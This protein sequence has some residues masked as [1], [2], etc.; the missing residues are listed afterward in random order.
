MQIVDNTYQV[1]DG[2]FISN[3]IGADAFGAENLIFPPIMIIMSI[4]LMFGSGSSAF[5]AKE[6]GE[7]H[8]EKANQLF[9]FLI[10]VLGAIGIVLSAVMFFLMPSIARLTGVSED[11]LPYCLDYSYILA[12]FMPFQVLSMAFHPLLI[13][14]ERP[15]LGLTVTISNAV[16]NILLD[17][18]FVAG[19]RWGMRGAALATGLAWCVSAVIPLVFFMKRSN[20]LH[21]VRPS[22]NLKALIGSMYN[23]VSEMVDSAAYAFVAVIFNLQLIRYLGNAG[24]EAYAVSEYASG[25]FNAVFYGIS[26]TIIPVAGYHL[27]KSN[28][29]ELHHLWHKGMLLMA[30]IGVCITGLCLLAADAVVRFF[31]GYDEILTGISVHAFRLVCLYFLLNGIT[32]YAGSYFTG[33]NQGTASLVIALARG[34]IGPLLFIRLLPLLIGVDGLWM[35]SLSSEILAG[36]VSLICIIWWWRKGE[37]RHLGES[38]DPQIR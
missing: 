15:G 17:W 24:V 10:I 1:A 16:V 34:L 37:D 2:Y 4:G 26:M 32:V 33:V 35:T 12:L 11:L 18:L 6:L 30:S 21:F 14:A 20:S 27:G 23:G 8:K 31:V 36:I 13:A 29:E 7:G 3:Y 22:A 25:F 38:S 9:S 28:K 19:F 5:L